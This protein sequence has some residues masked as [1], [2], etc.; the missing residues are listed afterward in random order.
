M[1]AWPALRAQ[2]HRHRQQEARIY[3]THSSSVDTPAQARLKTRA[4]GCYCILNS[5]AKRLCTREAR[6]EIVDLTAMGQPASEGG[7]RK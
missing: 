5:N 2:Q 3:T 7:G 6:T 1:R 4:R